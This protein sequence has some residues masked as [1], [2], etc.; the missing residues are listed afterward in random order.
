MS[1]SQIVTWIV[2][3]L[4]AGGLTGRVV[5]G[6]KAGFGWYRNAAL[7]LAGALVGGFVVRGLDLMPALDAYSIS[8]RDIVSAVAG[9][10]IVL[11]AWWLY[12]RRSSAAID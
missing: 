2:V 3:G 6:S 4:L 11:L 7:G 1:F 12:Q 10:V 9:S 8:L 5:T